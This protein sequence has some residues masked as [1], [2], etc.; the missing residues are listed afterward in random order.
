MRLG[1]GLSSNKI[2]FVHSLP[3][4][5]KFDN[6]AILCT[7]FNMENLFLVYFAEF[8][9]GF[10]QIVATLLPI[11][12]PP[13]GAAMFL[14]ATDSASSRT[15][16]LL[17][18]MVSRNCFLLMLAFILLG[19]LV[20][21]F[22]GISQDVVLIGGGLLVIKMGWDLVNADNTTPKHDEQLSDSFTPQKMKQTAFF[23]LSFPMTVGPG[24]LAA[25]ITVGA[26]FSA[27]S[28][29][30][31]ITRLFGGFIGIVTLALT[32][33]ICYGYADKI[34]SFLGE[35]GALVFM[36]ICAFILLCIG[37]QLVWNGLAN[38]VTELY[39]ELRPKTSITSDAPTLPAIN[40]HEQKFIKIPH[41]G[42]DTTSTATPS[43]TNQH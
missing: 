25:C 29:L 13:S 18:K 32:V 14:S 43:S 4:P 21:K 19:S 41:T 17:A 24:V 5:E 40:I 1:E 20:L 30:I 33:R 36:R 26:S 6:P 37:I 7:A 12:N 34:I 16:H 31:L 23:P 10:L 2:I 9:K 22:F 35:T 8:G 15:R 3:H 42:T 11:M 39:Y 28:H 27:P 38:S